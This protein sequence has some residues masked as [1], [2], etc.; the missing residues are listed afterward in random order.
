M[1]ARLQL[2]LSVPLIALALVFAPAR[3]SAAAQSNASTASSPEVKASP[4]DEKPQGRSPVDVLSDTGGA[5]VRSY[6]DR[7]L[8]IIKNRWYWR[9][10]ERAKSRVGEAKVAF[11]IGRDGEISDVR[12]LLK[13]GDDILD[14]AAFR[15]ITESSPLPAL[16]SDYHCQDLSLAIHFLYNMGTGSQNRTPTNLIPCVKTRITLVGNVGIAISPS[17]ATLETGATQKFVA[18]IKGLEGAAIQWS[19]SGSGCSADDCGSI[20]PEG[21]YTAPLRV[22]GE[23]Q[24][25]V[26]AT[27]ASE[28]DV[29]ASAAVTVK[30]SAANH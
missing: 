4:R 17:T 9:I 29:A 8:P 6:I 10:P 24:L 30:Q 7:I 27:V 12:Y 23:R 26:Q 11:R 21:L 14:Q 28:P 2:L 25:M 3:P 15:S 19:L 18:T 13:S 22:S 1:P 20:S 5:D 16:S